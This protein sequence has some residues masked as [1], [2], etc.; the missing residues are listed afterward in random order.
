MKIINLYSNFGE[1]CSLK[2]KKA[3]IGFLCKLEPLKLAE[4]IDSSVSWSGQWRPGKDDKARV[5]VEFKPSYFLNDPY[6]KSLIQ[7]IDYFRGEKDSGWCAWYKMVDNIMGKKIPLLQE[8]IE[9]TKNKI[10]ETYDPRIHLQTIMNHERSALPFVEDFPLPIKQLFD[11]AIS[12]QIPQDTWGKKQDEISEFTKKFTEKKEHLSR[13]M[14]FEYDDYLI[15]I[16]YPYSDIP[17]L[18]IKNDSIELNLCAPHNTSFPVKNALEET[19]EF[20]VSFYSYCQNLADILKEAEE[21]IRSTVSD[22]YKENI[23]VRSNYFCYSH[24][25]MNWWNLLDFKLKD[26]ESYRVKI[27]LD[28]SPAGIMI[29]I[30][31]IRTRQSATFWFFMANSSWIKIADDDFLQ[32]KNN[33]LISTFSKKVMEWLNE[34][35]ISKSK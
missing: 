4:E 23:S 34:Y 11:Y 8:A 1:L 12:C 33:E 13:R 20:P 28:V 9:S 25:N 14:L 22:I 10:L 24:Q 17:V 31:S 30:E 2:R 35:N 15:R 21:H 27:S 7:N 5:G 3:L 6:L 18:M 19:R 29:N 26:Q 32:L 16:S